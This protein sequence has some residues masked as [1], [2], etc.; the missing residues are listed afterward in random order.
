MVK[1]GTDVRALGMQGQ[2]MEEARRAVATT[3]RAA[4]TAVMSSQW[5]AVRLQLLASAVVTVIAVVA[6]LAHAKYIPESQDEVRGRGEG[7]MCVN[8]CM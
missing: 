3:T 1:G 6:V 5:L 8:Q 4:V 7:E 2:F